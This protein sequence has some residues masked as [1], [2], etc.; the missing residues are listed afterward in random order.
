M[1][2]D[3]FVA[4]VWEKVATSPQCWRK[5]QAVFNVIDENWDVAR[6]VQFVDG[7]D[8]FYDDD[9]IQEFI[10]HAWVIVKNKLSLV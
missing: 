10:D 2:Y 3:E 9:K 4:H 1:T 7:I 6:E 5:G 8:C